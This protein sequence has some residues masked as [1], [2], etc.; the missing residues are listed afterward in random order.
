MSR[1]TFVLTIIAV[2]LLG[3]MPFAARAF[4]PGSPGDP[5]YVV[6]RVVGVDAGTQSLQLRTHDQTVTVSTDTSTII[7]GVDEAYPA[8]E[9]T[10]IAFS[11]IRVGDIAAAIGRWQTDESLLAVSLVVN[12][13][14]NVRPI[15]GWI[16]AV[17][18]TDS[19][20]TIRPNRM[21]R[22]IVRYTSNTVVMKRDR[23]NRRWV[24][25]TTADLQVGKKVHIAAFA[26]YAAP[27]GLVAKS[28]KI[29]WRAG[30]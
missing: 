9:P 17:D 27:D 1:R 30:R 25:G 4:A 10:T 3:T 8:R 7:L 28:I 2:L 24:R 21:K 16:T 18:T 12:H 23:A 19:A 22:W 15:T 14:D 11:A 5:Q 20:L 6:G 13:K 26:A 29:L